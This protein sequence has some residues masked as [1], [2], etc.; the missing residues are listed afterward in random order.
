MMLVERF[1]VLVIGVG[2]MCGS[3]DV[4]AAVTCV[5][6][7]LNAIAATPN[8]D[9]DTAIQPIFNTRCAGCHTGG[10]R[11]GNLNLDRPSAVQHLVNVRS[12]NAFAGIPL[13][14]PGDP[15]QSFLF[16]KLNC[17]NLNA[18]LGVRMPFKDV[19]V[20]FNNFLSPADQALI[21][22]WVT[23][24]AKAEAATPPPGPTLGAGFS[25]N[26][27]DPDAGQDGHGFQIEVLPDNGMLVIWFVFNPAGTAQNWI[28]SQGSYDPASNTVTLPAFL[29]TGGRFP[30][31]FDSAALSRTPWGALTL[32]FSDCS[33]GGAI[34]TPN[35]ASEAAGYAGVSFPIRRVTSVAGT[36]CP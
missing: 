10:A 7:D 12:D 5:G 22:D 4:L 24:G 9:F 19:S 2:L 18:N 11:L 26:W 15:D 32:S 14:T 34:W 16:K 3:A 8:V 29:E 21:R 1:R 20:P 28:Y 35:A 23:Q 17:T 25:G 31:N 6:D 30:P 13:V 27:F 33:N 36:T